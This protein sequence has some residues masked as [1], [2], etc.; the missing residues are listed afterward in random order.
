MSE[1]A[2]GTKATS[3]VLGGILATS[4]HSTYS[5]FVLALILGYFL[6]VRN[7]DLPPGPLKLAI[8]GNIWWVLLQR[9]RGKRIAQVMMEAVEK[10][11][12]VN[13]L[14]FFN[15]NVIFFNRPDTIFDA[16]VKRAD[17]LSH[18]PQWLLKDLRPGYGIVFAN[19]HEWKTIRRFSLLALKG[20]HKVTNQVSF[21]RNLS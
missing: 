7:K 6:F 3:T 1:T 4:I 14:T 17:D 19:G 11:S 8:I 12:N 15:L 13:H 9:L 10:Y 2:T 20:K 18:R 5:V 21:L 16:F